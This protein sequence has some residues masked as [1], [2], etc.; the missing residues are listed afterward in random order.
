MTTD[1]RR[2]CDWGLVSQ[3]LFSF[4]KFSY[5][6]VIF[7]GNFSDKGKLVSEHEMISTGQKGSLRD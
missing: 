6:G 3:R 2:T 7:D 4:S 1:D 5:G